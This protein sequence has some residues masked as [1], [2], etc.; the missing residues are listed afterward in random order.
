MTHLTNAD[1]YIN[2][3]AVNALR[4]DY[5][6]NLDE[7]V[8]EYMVHGKWHKVNYPNQQQMDKDFKQLLNEIENPF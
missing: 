6:E 7:W 4:T 2:D 3:K 8:L 5:N 1:L